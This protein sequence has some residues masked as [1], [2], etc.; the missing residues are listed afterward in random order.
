MSTHTQVSFLHA[1]H[2]ACHY[3][4]LIFPIA[5]L[6]IERDWA[7][8]YGTALAVGTPAY[9]CFALAT[10]PA[11][12][13]G[14]R[15]DS[16]YLI[17]LFFIGCGAASILIAMAPDRLWLMAGLSLLGIFAAIYH[18]VGLAMVTRLSSRPGRAL[19][20]NGVFGN[21]G[22]AA[23]ALSTGLLADAFGWRSAFL[24]PGI[25]TFGVGLA[26]LQAH[27]RPLIAGSSPSHHLAIQEDDHLTQIRVLGVVLFAAFFSGLVFNGVT[28]SL[29]KLFEER[30]AD[31]AGNLS[32]IGGYSA[33]V[34][35]AAAF[36]Q[37]PVGAL[38]DRV[39]GRPVWLALFVLLV[40]ALA[41]T[42]QLRGVLVIPAALATVTLLFAGIPITGWLLARYVAVNWRSRAFAAEYVLALG[43]SSIVVPLVATLHQVG[44]GFD[45]QYLLFALSAAVVAVS[46]LALPKVRRS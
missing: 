32:G 9:V 29:P 15:W 39:G 10:L 41:A 19:A 22:L 8:D 33:F 25:V 28:I 45:R 34:F 43:T 23:A 37:L 26:Y 36:A 40:G 31:K 6:A 2:F 3:F 11:G 13:L 35:A 30:L 42:S 20:V 7:L 24:V 1:A 44:F 18:P 38:L 46:A 12:W 5:V 16:E 14:D 17:G 4:L 27:R 21:L